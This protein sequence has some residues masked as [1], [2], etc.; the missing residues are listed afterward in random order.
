M[1]DAAKVLSR[2]PKIN[3]GERRLFAYMDSIDWLFRRDGRWRAYQAQVDNGRLVEKV[4][5]PCRRF[6]EWQAR[7]VGR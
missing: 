3:T 2:D 6:A 4:G 1:A 7:Q 5:K